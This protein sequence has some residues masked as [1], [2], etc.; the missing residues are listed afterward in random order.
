MTRALAGALLSLVLLGGC[1]APAPTPQGPT[2]ASQKARGPKGGFLM[3]Y[4][5]MGMT[6]EVVVEPGGTVRVYGYA[7]NGEQANLNQ[8]YPRNLTMVEL[9]YL[10]DGAVGVELSPDSERG[11]LMAVIDIPR[12]REILRAPNVTV[13]LR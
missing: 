9:R 8:F 4:L 7:E 11:C 6:V 10:P 3:E 13:M 2:P 12:A 5:Y 1:P